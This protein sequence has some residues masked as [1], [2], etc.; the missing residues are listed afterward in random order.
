MSVVARGLKNSFRNLIRTFSVT[1]I[2]GISIGLA[3]VMMLAYQ[4]VSTRIETVKTTIGNTIS[5]DPAGGRGFEGGGEPLTLTEMNQIRTLAHVTN[6]QETLLARVTTET[7]TSLASAIDPGTLGNR[8][9]QFNQRAFSGNGQQ[10]SGSDT[11][12][13]PTFRIPITISGLS[14]PSSLT[15]SPSSLSSG[16]VFQADSNED[17]AVLGKS[18]AE[19]NS[20]TVGSTFTA[21]GTTITVVGISDGGN[22]FANNSVSMPLATVQRLSSQSDEISSATVTVDSIT[23]LDE[24]V[25]AIQG[26]LGAD[27][28][29]VTSNATSAKQALEPLEN[30]KHISLYSLLGALLAGAVITF[31][32]MLMI[33]RERRREIGVL[34]AI[35]ASNISV[36]TQ[37]VAE[38]VVLTFIGGIFGAV[39]GFFLSNPILSALVSNQAAT[40]G[41][42]LGGAGGRGAG[43]FISFAQGGGLATIGSSLRTVQTVVHYDILLYGLAAAL[44]IA[45]VG[46]A[47]PAWLIA[48]VRPAEVLRGE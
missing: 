7:D 23:N 20:L 10:R 6:V 42:A 11:T 35:G 30:V 2:L 15:D 17:V 37:F 40:G 19:K 22:Q 31:L 12:S 25:T 34:K 45:I 8:Q 24:T 5:I 48:H 27:K 39:L 47:V 41:A 46:S 33:V 14:N 21:Y 4:A 16:E 36:I 38:S 26:Q 43:G 28:A 29:D 32:I 9:N 1:V 13:T 44:V 3:L 18:I